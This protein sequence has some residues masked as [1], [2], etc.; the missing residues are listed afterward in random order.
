MTMLDI[1]D[2]YPQLSDTDIQAALA[3]A[4][5]LMRDISRAPFVS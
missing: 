1:R 2:A 3:Y 5:E 4:A